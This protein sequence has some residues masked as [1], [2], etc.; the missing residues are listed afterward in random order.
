MNSRP[1]GNFVSINLA[2]GPGYRYR[3]FR[4]AGINVH[5]WFAVTHRYSYPGEIPKRAAILRFAAM[6]HRPTGLQMVER[7]K[8]V[9]E[10]KR[11]ANILA[12]L[13]IPW[14]SAKQKRIVA[15]ENALPPKVRRWMKEIIKYGLS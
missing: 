1:V 8:S 15:A 6:T 3:K 14:Q 11:L 2:Q 4:S 12:R 9:R 7:L 5:R 10:G 13:P